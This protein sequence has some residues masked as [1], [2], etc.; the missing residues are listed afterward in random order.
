MN[1]NTEGF[2]KS[3]SLVKNNS[4]TNLTNLSNS[5]IVND[6]HENSNSNIY[7]KELFNE[8]FMDIDGDVSSSRK[9]KVNKGDK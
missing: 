2:N 1:Q 8:D 4:M 7:I 3:I 9:I 6:K 5:F